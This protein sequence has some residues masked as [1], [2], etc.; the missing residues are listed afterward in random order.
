MCLQRR[1]NSIIYG[2]KA[3]GTTDAV[4]KANE[5]FYRIKNLFISYRSEQD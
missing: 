3:A 1:N 2:L 4:I 5:I